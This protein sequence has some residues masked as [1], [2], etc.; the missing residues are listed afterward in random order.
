M[1]PGRQ[2][3][4][5]PASAKTPSV[6]THAE[7]DA[8]EGEA[9]IVG[10]ITLLGNSILIEG[11]PVSRLGMRE[12]DGPGQHRGGDETQQGHGERYAHRPGMSAGGSC[13]SGRTEPAPSLR[14]RS[15]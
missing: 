5:P 10:Y 11:I 9:A 14:S 3:S 12:R 8:S 7:A 13:E 4:P 2:S 15:S 1:S 6:E